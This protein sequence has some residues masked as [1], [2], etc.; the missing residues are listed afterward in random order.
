MRP[1]RV[2]GM[3]PVVPPEQPSKR[4]ARRPLPR[5]Q[6]HFE[7]VVQGYVKALKAPVSVTAAA[8]DRAARLTRST[9]EG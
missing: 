4:F 9:P 1:G 5:E 7:R 6:R 8:A 3:R 2:A